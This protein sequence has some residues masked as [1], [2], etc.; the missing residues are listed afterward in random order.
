M[1]FDP[2]TLL[3]SLAAALETGF[4]AHVS[5]EKYLAEIAA[6]LVKTPLVHPLR[7][8]PM[9]RPEPEEHPCI[10]WDA[11]QDMARRIQRAEVTADELRAFAVRLREGLPEMRRTGWGWRL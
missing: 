1:T 11:V 2:A 7:M 9:P 10:A 6:A 4:P 5:R 8:A 3:D